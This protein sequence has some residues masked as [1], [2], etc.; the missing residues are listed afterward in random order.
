ML[1]FGTVRPGQ[2]LYIPFD[3]FAG[4]TGA[5]VTMTGLAVTDIEVYKDGSVTQRASDNGYTLLDTDG[6]DFDG[7]TGIHGFSINLADNTTSGFWTAGSKYTVVVSAI[8]VDSQ[9]VSFIAAVFEIGYP[10]AIINTTIATLASQTSFTLTSGPAED[11]ALNGMWV[12]IHDIASAVQLGWGQILDYTGST[13]TVTLAAALPNFTVAAGDNISVMG[14]TPLQPATIGR[15]LA[16]ESD[17]MA[18][19]DLKEIAAAAVSTASAQLGVNVVNAGGTAWGSGAITAAAIATNAIDADALAAD[20][21]AEIQSGLAT[22][23]ALDTVD[24]FLDTEIAAILADT[25]ELQTDWA[26]G[27]RLDLLIDAILADTNELQTDWANGGRLDLLIDAILEDTGTTLPATLDTIDN[28]LDTEIAAILADTDELQTDW[29]NGGRLD[30]LID[31]IKAK[32]DNLPVAVKKN[33]ALAKF[34]FKM[35]DSADHVTPKTGLTVTCQ[36]SIDGAAFANCNTAT[37]TE[38]SAGW[39]YV[40]L[41]ASDLNGNVIA[42][43]FTATGADQRDLLVVTQT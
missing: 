22:A 14:P 26:N 11:D 5:S 27:G 32:T 33:T 43:K 13:K 40:D 17:G 36:R 6:I 37:A 30:L 25:N 23:A 41:A 42:L 15:T 10:G 31:A 12:L 3:T 28:F 1:N 21:V 38:I 34:M 24:N 19:A 35:V 18:H 2:T 39:Y 7:L 9:T 8:T 29:V 4:A 20:A 16:V